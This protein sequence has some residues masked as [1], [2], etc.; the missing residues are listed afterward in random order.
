MIEGLY[1]RFYQFTH[2]K[3]LS[4]LLAYLARFVFFLR[5]LVKRVLIQSEKQ[6]IDPDCA[7]AIIADT[8][9]DLGRAADYSVSSLDP[10]IDLSVIV[11]VY[12]HID[13]IGR[14]IDGLLNQKTGFR[15]ELI[16]VDDGSTDG[17]QNLIERYRAHPHVVLIHQENGG[18]AAA[19]NTGISRARGR[20]LM[21]VDCD[22]EVK[23]T[24]VESLMQAAVA[25]DYDIVMCGHN[26]VKRKDGVI[27]S[28][29][30]YVHPG[31]NLLG[32]RNGDEIM[33]Y[34]GLPWAKV[35]KR[36]LFEKVRFFPG[37]WYEDTI[38]H[39]LLFPQCKTFRYVP[40][41]LYDYNWYE[42]NFSHVQAGRQSKPKA[43]DRYWLL[44]AITEN[45]DRIGLPHDAKFYTILLKHV[46]AYYYPTVS[47]LPEEVVQ[48]MFFAGRELLLKYKPQEKV[49]LPYMLRQTEKAILEKNIALWK[50][51]SVNQ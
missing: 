12:N 7:E 27:T 35:Y 10:D 45:Y 30:P 8:S 18:I 41:A 32:Y 43:V 31:K 44:K 29:I 36:E 51:C 4:I 9:P 16:L 33:N 14:C 46:S 17:A 25:G 39:C 23:D 3:S 34:A 26:L 1:Y 6:L 22:D 5:F 42:G 13:V 19:R 48:A 28:I 2:S 47:S 11:P 20:Y 15:F 21:F 49:K 37:Y 50:L 24:L 38:V 40:S